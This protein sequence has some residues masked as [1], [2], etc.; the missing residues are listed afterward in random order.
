MAERLHFHPEH[1]Q[2]H[3]ANAATAQSKGSSFFMSMSNSAGQTIIITI[4]MSTSTGQSINWSMGRVTTCSMFSQALTQTHTQTQT[5][6]QK[7]RHRHTQIHTQTQTQTQNDVQTQ[8]RTCR[9]KKIAQVVR[10]THIYQNMLRS[11][12]LRFQCARSKFWT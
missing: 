11:W 10:C 2:Q 12:F 3:N 8:L 1:E 5:R 7:E 4:H 9:S 6:T